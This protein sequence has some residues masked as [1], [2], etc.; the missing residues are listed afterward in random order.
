MRNINH[1]SII[2]HT[3]TDISCVNICFID[4]L[5]FDFTGG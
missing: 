3:L 5:R 2:A 4:L 1:F